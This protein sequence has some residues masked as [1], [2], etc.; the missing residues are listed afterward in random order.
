MFGLYGA[1]RTDEL[2]KL[3]IND[4]QKQGNIF[5]VDLHDTKTTDRS[6]V[7]KGPYVKIVEKYIDVRPEHANTDRFFL[8]IIAILNAPLN[9]LVLI[10]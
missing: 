3:K 8:L 6:F 1:T 10:R 4:V 9:R 7:I 5:V 2:V